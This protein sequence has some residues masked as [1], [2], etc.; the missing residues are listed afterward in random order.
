MT[1]SGTVITGVSKR[2]GGAKHLQEIE[3]QIP[4]NSQ[5]EDILRYDFS[6][7]FHPAIRNAIVRAPI[8]GGVY[9]VYEI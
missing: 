9:H 2:S 6:G 8:E 5:L 1:D 4:A 7:D 3:D